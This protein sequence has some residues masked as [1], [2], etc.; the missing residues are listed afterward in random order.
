MM[1]LFNRSVIFVHITKTGGGTVELALHQTAQQRKLRL[2]L[3][4]AHR[5]LDGFIAETRRMHMSVEGLQTFTIVRNPWDR[6]VS[7]YSFFGRRPGGARPSDALFEIQNR[8]FDAWLRYIYSPA[9][10]AHRTVHHVNMLRHVFGNQLDWLGPD[11]HRVRV[12]RFERW[13][14]EVIP[15]LRDELG[16]NVSGIRATTHASK[17]RSFC[18]YYSAATQALVARAYERDIIELNYSFPDCSL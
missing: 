3:T 6:M 9:W 4:G 10:P 18:T 16:L 14:D 5:T 13:E 15:Y 17:H 11:T 12:L 1:A 8:S 7:T 2:Q